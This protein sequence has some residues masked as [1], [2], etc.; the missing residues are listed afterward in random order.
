MFTCN[1]SK[2]ALIVKCSKNISVRVMNSLR[3]YSH[4]HRVLNFPHNNKLF[5]CWKLKKFA[6]KSSTRVYFAQHIASTC[7]TEICCVASWARGSNTSNNAFQLAMQQCCATSLTKK[8]PVLLG[9]ERES[10]LHVCL[11]KLVVKEDITSALR[12]A[13][14]HSKPL[15]KSKMRISTSTRMINIFFY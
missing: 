1:Y 15:C 3:C 5:Q 12:N 8:L 11:W 7:N 14:R 4:Y 2:T 10:R 9:L 6:A 13:H